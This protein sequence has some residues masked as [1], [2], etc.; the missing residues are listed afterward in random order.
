MGNVLTSKQVEELRG[1]LEQERARIRAVLRDLPSPSPQPDQ[2]T[3]LEEA[4]QRQT[5]RTHDDEVAARERA[6]LAEVERA[7]A[8]IDEG[9]YGVSERSGT[10][11]P[12]ERLRAMPWARDA[13][14]E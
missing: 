5:E 1:R 12:Y 13:I 14:D 6:L 9:G 3:E 11:I 8:K 2:E 4:A 10:P 7:L